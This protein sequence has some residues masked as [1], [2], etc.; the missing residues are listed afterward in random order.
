LVGRALSG[1][2]LGSALA[3]AGL[4]SG[5]FVGWLAIRIIPVRPEGQSADYDDAPRAP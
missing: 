3:L 5:T 2:I 4:F 1:P